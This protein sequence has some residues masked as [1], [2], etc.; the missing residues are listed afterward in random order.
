MEIANYKDLII[1]QRAMELTEEVY[2][3]VNLL[4]KDEVFVLSS[5]IRRAAIS[6]P[7]NIAE[8]HARNSTKDYLRFLS[9]AKGS[10][11]EL[12]TQLYLAVRL[13]L[14]E[15]ASITKALSLSEGSRQNAHSTNAKTP[16]N[17]RMNYLYP[18]PTHYP[19]FPTPYSLLPTPYSLFPKEVLP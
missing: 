12:E 5:Q 2:Q 9:I 8:G 13:H 19:L 1:W 16:G 7:S 3:V 4:P 15:E 11:A 14:I 10:K 6:I 17:N 18:I